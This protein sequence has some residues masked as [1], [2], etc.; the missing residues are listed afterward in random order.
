MTMRVTITT[1][2]VLALAVLASAQTSRWSYGLQAGVAGHM[3]T[4]TLSDNFKGAIGFTGGLYCSTPGSGESH[5][6][7][8]TVLQPL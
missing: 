7:Y 2:L 3:T 5:S 8:R 6:V 4:G 1:I